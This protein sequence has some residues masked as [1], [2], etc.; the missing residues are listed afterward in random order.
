MPLM[1]ILLDWTQ[2]RKISELGDISGD[3]YK[4]AKEKLKSLNTVAKNCR[5]ANKTGSMQQDAR[6][7]KGDG[8]HTYCG[9]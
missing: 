9:D 6:R 8:R 1:D 4:D 5:A 2:M 3:T 7:E